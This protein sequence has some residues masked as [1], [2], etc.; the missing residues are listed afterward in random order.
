M[1]Q[2][3]QEKLKYQLFLLYI[4]VKAPGKG[5]KYSRVIKNR[6]ECVQICNNHKL[7]YQLIQNSLFTFDG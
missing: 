4:V 7:L 5:I 1:L 2:I 6:K 3:Y